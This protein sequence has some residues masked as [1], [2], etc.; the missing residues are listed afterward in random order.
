MIFAQGRTGS[1]LL[2]SLLNS[3]PYVRCDGEIL[4]EKVEDPI[5]YVEGLA[6]KSPQPVYGFKVKIYQLADAQ[7]VDPRG[8]LEELRKRS[9]RI[10]YLRRT[11]LLRH[12][13]SNEFAVA[14]DSY[15]DRADGP[16]PA[17]EV[18]PDKVLTLMRRRQNHLENEAAVL[19]GFDYL[20]LEYEQDLL[21]SDRH[22]ATADAVFAHLGLEPASVATD[23]FRSVSGSLADRIANYDELSAAVESSEF[24]HF[25]ND[26]EYR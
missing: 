5:G 6:A 13:I 12:V 22:Q 25:V 4:N 21:R 11:N 26:P 8:F 24:A 16:R 18:N 14:R 15:H 17:I 3:H 23:L 1:S 9:Y 10:I 20:P 7:Q 2:R 19:E